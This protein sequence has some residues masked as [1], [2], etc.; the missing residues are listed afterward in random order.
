MSETPEEAALLP[1]RSNAGLGELTAFQKWV[2]HLTA[3][4]GG[5]CA[6]SRSIT[7]KERKECDALVSAGMLERAKNHSKDTVGMYVR[8]NVEITG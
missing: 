4:G 7:A 5:L 1:V 6:S 3:K 8:P 2:L